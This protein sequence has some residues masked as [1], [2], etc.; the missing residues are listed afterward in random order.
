MKF[1]VSKCKGL[2]DMETKLG[3]SRQEISRCV[4]SYGWLGHLCY[5]QRWG[6]FWFSHTEKCGERKF[7][8]LDKTSP[9]YTCDPLLC[10]FMVGEGEWRESSYLFIFKVAVHRKRLPVLFK[11][12]CSVRRNVKWAVDFLFQAQGGGGGGGQIFLWHGSGRA[13]S[14]RASLESFLSP[15][16]SPTPQINSR[17]SSLSST[18][19]CFAPL[20]CRGQKSG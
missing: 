5:K 19:V 12:G 6:D 20:H 7:L 11:T 18:V 17:S 3:L 2:G 1:N 14:C 4:L 9:F 10:R 16:L 15:L 13:W 8:S